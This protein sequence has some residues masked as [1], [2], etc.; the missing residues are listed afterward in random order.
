MFTSLLDRLREEHEL[1]VSSLTTTIKDL[2]EALRKA[3]G[4][5]APKCDGTV[6][7]W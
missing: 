2:D 6:N 1:Q 4:S 7:Q 3:G 5:L